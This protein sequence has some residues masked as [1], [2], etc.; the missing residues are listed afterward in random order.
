[1]SQPRVKPLQHPYTGTIAASIWAY[2]VGHGQVNFMAKNNILRGL[3]LRRALYKT[4]R[5]V[6]VCASLQAGWGE[7]L[8][9]RV[10]TRISDSTDQW[11]P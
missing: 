7:N 10:G 9:K 3:Q 1:M 5:R 2:R 11:G 8:D 6:C 4:R